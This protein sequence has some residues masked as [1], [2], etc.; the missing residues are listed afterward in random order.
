M[1]GKE[2][3]IKASKEI[4][5]AFKKVDRTFEEANKVRKTSF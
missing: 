3:Q 4:Y 2:K 5:R 1:I